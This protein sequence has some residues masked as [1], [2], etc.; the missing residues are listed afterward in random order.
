MAT[1]AIIRLLFWIA[2]AFALI[3]AGCKGANIVQ[4]ALSFGIAAVLIS[5]ILWVCHFIT[6]R[7]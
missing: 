2:V 1:F 3:A 5:C 7:K 4:L 6:K